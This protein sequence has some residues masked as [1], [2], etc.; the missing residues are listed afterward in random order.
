MSRSRRGLLGEDGDLRMRIAAVEKQ[1]TGFVGHPPN[2][3]KVV[4]PIHGR[5]IDLYLAGR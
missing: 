2:I 3:R 5:D 1:A 4:M